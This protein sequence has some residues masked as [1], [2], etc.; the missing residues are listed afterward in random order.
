MLVERVFIGGDNS[1]KARVIVVI[2]RQN[3]F[4][5]LARFAHDAAVV[6]IAPLPDGVGHSKPVGKTRRQ[7]A[8]HETRPRGFTD[9]DMVTN[10][11]A[12]Q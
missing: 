1:I 7:F 6:A 4:N 5:V 8:R 9:A 11:A 3:N 10:I 12:E 2:A